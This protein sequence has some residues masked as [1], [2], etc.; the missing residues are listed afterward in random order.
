MLGQWVLWKNPKVNDFLYC[1]F[2]IFLTS[3]LLKK[4]ILIYIDVLIYKDKNIISHLR[5]TTGQGN[6]ILPCP[7]NLHRI[8]NLSHALPHKAN[9][10]TIFVPHRGKIRG[11]SPIPEF[12]PSRGGTNSL[13]FF[14]K[15]KN[16][17]ESDLFD[18][19]FGGLIIFL[20]L[21]FIFFLLDS[22]I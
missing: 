6:L 7:K 20:Y 15:I 9:F 3:K 22:A 12:L 11:A 13:V 1:N 18:L 2:L 14:F 16:K 10:Y 19:V 8:K 21:F 4:S 17:K 5:C